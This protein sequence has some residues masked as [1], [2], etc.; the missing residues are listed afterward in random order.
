MLFIVFIRDVF[1]LSEDPI[2]LLNV[3]NACKTHISNRKN[4]IIIKIIYIKIT[5]LKIIFFGLHL[6]LC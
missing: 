4:Y 5:I 2:V 1:S 6:A 3:Q